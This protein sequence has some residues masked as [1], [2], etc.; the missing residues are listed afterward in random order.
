[1]DN[2]NAK[3][4]LGKKGWFK[5]L[6]LRVFHFKVTPVLPIIGLGILLI[7]IPYSNKEIKIDLMKLGLM[8]MVLILS[9]L[10]IKLIQLK[11]RLD[12]K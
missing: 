1:M 4:E 11:E 9:G 12:E 6:R 7:L 8:T 5:S 3:E 10:T 2:F